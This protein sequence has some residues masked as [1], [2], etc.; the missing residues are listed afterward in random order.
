M[1]SLE[2]GE[3]AKMQL[4]RRLVRDQKPPRIITNRDDL[5]DFLEERRAEGGSIYFDDGRDTRYLKALI[6]PATLESIRGASTVQATSSGLLLL[7]YALTF[8]AAEIYLA[9]ID[10]GR[11][12]YFWGPSSYPWRHDDIDENFVRIVGGRFKN[13]YSASDKSPAAAYLPVRSF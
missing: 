13:V 9:G 2:S 5:P 10:F 1:V 8:G 7:Q 11:G 4:I 6:R 3:T 12:G